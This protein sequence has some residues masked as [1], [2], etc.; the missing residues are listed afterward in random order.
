[1]LRLYPQFAT[2]GDIFDHCP[3]DRICK[4]LSNTKNTLYINIKYLKRIYAYSY[5]WL[6]GVVVSAL[7]IRA[8]CPGFESRGSQH[9]SI[10]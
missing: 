9:Y 6:S 2:L 4:Y 7:G 8:R 5:V 3:P 10:G 1:M